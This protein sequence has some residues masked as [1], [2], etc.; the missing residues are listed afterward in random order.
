MNALR[1]AKPATRVAVSRWDSAMSTGRTITDRFIDMRIALESLF[2]PQQPDQ[3]LKFL[4]TV[5]GAWMIGRD[6]PDR[7]RVYETLRRAYDLGSKAVH[8]GGVKHS[9]ANAALLNTALAVC[10]HGILR[11]LHHGP[12]DNWNGL[13]LDQH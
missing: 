8:R 2:L 11:A 13:I 4:F 7:K 9:S 1:D 6:G 12:V 5:I 3:E 10:R